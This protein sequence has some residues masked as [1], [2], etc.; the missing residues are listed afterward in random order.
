V[1][2]DDLYIDCRLIDEYSTWIMGERKEDF[3]PVSDAYTFE[4][5]PGGYLDG[6]SIIG[7]LG[8]DLPAIVFS[9]ISEKS[10]HP[11]V[12]NWKDDIGS[13]S[14]RISI[15]TI[16]IKA[17]KKLGFIA[18]LLNDLAVEN[19]LKQ[20]QEK[21]QITNGE[22][23]FF[24]DSKRILI[25]HQKM[26]VTIGTGIAS[27]IRIGEKEYHSLRSAWQCDRRS[28]TAIETRWVYEF[29]IQTIVWQ[30]DETGC[31][32]VSVSFAVKEPCRIDDVQLFLYLDKMI[33]NKYVITDRDKRELHT[34]GIICERNQGP[35]S[36]TFANES[37]PFCID[38]FCDPSD[39]IG[40]ELDD[41]TE[42]IC[43][44]IKI[45]KQM[46]SDETFRA[47]LDF[48][49][50]EGTHFA[51]HSVCHK[52]LSFIVQSKSHVLR[53][54]NASL[55][56]SLGLY[57]SYYHAEAGWCDAVHHTH[58]KCHKISDSEMGLEIMWKHIPIKQLWQ[59]KLVDENIV[60]WAIQ[61]R[62]FERILFQKE[63]IN[64]MLS[65]HYTGWSAE[66]AH[67]EF[68]HAFTADFG[69]DWDSLYETHNIVQS[70]TFNSKNSDI[71]LPGATISGQP[72]YENV[73]LQILNSDDV[74]RGR[75]LRFVR[76]ESAYNSG[77]YEYFR[78]KIIIEK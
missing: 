38:L 20:E 41:G 23:S 52:Q 57:S 2:I 48:K 50:S 29:G 37:F 65:P 4:D 35:F 3:I 49:P 46:Q 39:H 68:P 54:Y 77:T 51:E 27:I 67:G 14:L 60:E 72:E 74:F 26:P 15:E 53:W 63:Q 66:D 42:A 75:V 16:S 56:Q 21:K 6:A 36:L 33:L 5:V 45:H 34:R 78:G 40:Y 25:S 32:D 61:M 8:P 70:F 44:L 7:V 69:S 19:L 64:V 55:T 58:R 31:I 71:E 59:I 18:D 1:R 13:R 30:I 73:K 43:K 28:A 17:T 62:V 10:F 24:A 22:T 11:R 47:K 76:E 12:L 9:H